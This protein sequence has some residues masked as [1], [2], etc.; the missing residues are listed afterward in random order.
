MIVVAFLFVGCNEEADLLKDSVIYTNESGDTELDKWI[1]ENLTTPYNV[2]VIWKWEGEQ[3]G[4]DKFSV[5]AQ[6]EKA[7]AFLKAYLNAWIKPYEKVAGE[8][9]VKKHGFKQFVIA[10]APSYNEDGTITLGFAEGGR[11]VVVFNINNFE[12][13]NRA[14]F[15]KAFHVIHHEFA[16]ILHQ[17]K[18]YPETYKTISKDYRFDWYTVHPFI[19]NDKGFITPYSMADE[20]EDFV[21]MYSGMTDRTGKKQTY[22]VPKKDANGKLMTDNPDSIKE[23]TRSGFEH[24]IQY[25]EPI[26]VDMEMTEWEHYLYML[27]IKNS[28]S[29]PEM[30]WWV[31]GYIQ[32]EDVRTEGL[33]KMLAK[34]VIVRD[35][36]EDVWNLNVR[37]LQDALDDA[38]EIYL[39]E[40]E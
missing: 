34:E 26:M 18:L 9:F 39:S 13:T 21:E 36:F 38:I 11:K 27:G 16:H 3:I 25:G 17:L 8:N 10:G 24:Y 35:Y 6:V 5:P 4:S 7:E 22:T 19:A 1:M 28:D 20:N 30:L 15:A 14:E 23:V 12:P 40:N 33:S 2:E 31:T 37:D 29:A 32:S